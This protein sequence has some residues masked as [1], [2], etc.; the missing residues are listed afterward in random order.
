MAVSLA[1]DYGLEV[2]RSSSGALRAHETRAN[3]VT[4]SF[5]LV[6]NEADCNCI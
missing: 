6:R 1:S 5:P 2:I 3:H 4:V